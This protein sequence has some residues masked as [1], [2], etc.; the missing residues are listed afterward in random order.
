MLTTKL[1][2]AWP[3]LAWVAELRQGDPAVRMFHGPCVETAEDW[4]AE[5]V[6]AGDFAAGD[7][8]RTDLVFGSGIR[9][10]DGH[11]MFVSSGTV[12]DRLVYSYTHRD[13][14]V[15]NSLPALLAFANLDL[16]DDYENY[17]ADAR[18][19]MKGLDQRAQTIP[20]TTHALRSVF[21]NNLVF[22]GR[23][24]REIVKPDTTPGFASFSDYRDFL[25]GNRSGPYVA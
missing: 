3:K 16:R 11:V 5:A 10:R 23:S 13:S 1:L 21:Y 22:D 9:I 7:F 14:T 12:F 6:W 17:S 20:T 25:L 24:L 18:S 19:I 8:D 15:S 4:C 2:P